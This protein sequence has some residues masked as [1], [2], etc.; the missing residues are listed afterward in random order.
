MLTSDSSESSLIKFTVVS[1]PSPDEQNLDCEDVG[2]GT[3][4][5][6]EIL[7]YNQDKIQEDILIYDARETSTVIGSLN[8][9]IKALDALFTSTNFF[10]F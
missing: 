9:S 10:E 5:L 8:V 1:E 7:E 3:I 4:D 2:Y 6:R